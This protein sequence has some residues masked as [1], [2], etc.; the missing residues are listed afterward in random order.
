MVALLNALKQLILHLLARTREIGRRGG[1]GVDCDDDP[2]S[3][4]FL[5]QLCDS[6]HVVLYFSDHVVDFVDSLLVGGLDL[7]LVWSLGVGFAY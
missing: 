4:R 3:L 6:L 2:V 5:I 1:R 7:Q